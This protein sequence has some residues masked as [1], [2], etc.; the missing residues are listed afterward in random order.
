NDIALIIN[1]VID[2]LLKNSISSVL[3]ELPR[4]GLD[5]A[6]EP[7]INLFTAKIADEKFIRNTVGMLEDKFNNYISIEELLLKTGIEYKSTIEELIKGRVEAMA[8][9]NS[10]KIKITEIVS[11]MI[12][13]IVDIEM[14]SIFKGKGDKVPQAISRVVKDLY[15]KF[16]ENKASDVIEVLDVAKIVEDK[17]NEFD[18]AFSE[19]IILEI[20]RKELNAITWL[21]ALLGSIMGILAPILGTL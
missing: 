12:N 13:R 15:N 18:V 4:E 20:A 6:I 5:D 9:S 10:V 21:G 2:K 3:S 7:L 8:E 14:S 1:D 16:I 17:I 19:E 11:V